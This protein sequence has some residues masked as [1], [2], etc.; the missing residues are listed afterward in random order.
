[1]HGPDSMVQKSLHLLFFKRFCSKIMSSFPYMKFELYTSKNDKMVLRRP[2]YSF[3]LCIRFSLIHEWRCYAYA[4]GG[5][6]QP[7]LKRHQELT[8]LKKAQILTVTS[9]C[10]SS[11]R[12]SNRHFSF[13]FLLKVIKIQFCVKMVISSII[14][15]LK[16]NS[17]DLPVQMFVP[18]IS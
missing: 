16:T 12:A 6:S 11:D 2:E 13:V 14:H 4:E 9:V 8:Y 10:S 7:P 15:S 3:N 1:M 5:Y 18:T 17:D